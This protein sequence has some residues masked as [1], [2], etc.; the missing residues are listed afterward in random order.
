MQRG[1]VDHRATEGGGA[2]A[3]GGESQPI[4]PAAPSSFEAPLDAD[5]VP[6]GRGTFA[7]RC[8]GFL[9]SLKLGADVLSGHHHMW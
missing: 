7:V 9:H 4:E 2:V 6:A 1:L 8:E 3:L 5:L